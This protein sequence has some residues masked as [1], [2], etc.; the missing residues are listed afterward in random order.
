M[1]IKR[2]LNQLINWGQLTKMWYFQK[3]LCLSLANYLYSLDDYLITTTLTLHTENALTS[4]Q[5]LSQN[6]PYT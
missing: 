6:M 5:M 4:C 2:Q 1:L 3:E